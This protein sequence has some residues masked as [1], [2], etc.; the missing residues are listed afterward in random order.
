MKK[1]ADHTAQAASSCRAS[2]SASLGKNAEPAWL[3]Q[4]CLLPLPLLLAFVHLSVYIFIVY[5]CA[6][7]CVHKHM[8]MS[9]CVCTHVHVCAHMYGYA[10][11][12]SNEDI[13]ALG[14]RVT[15]VDG[16]S[17]GPLAHKK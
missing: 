7:V 3:P 6:C 14:A 9:V 5:L 1:E 8:Y 2:L 13:E 16:F 4:I 17:F 10:Q 15:G 11:W 12:G